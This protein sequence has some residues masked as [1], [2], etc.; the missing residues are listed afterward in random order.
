MIPDI[1]P[2]N[3]WAGNGSNTTFDFDFLINKESELQVLHTSKDG[4]QTELQLNKDYTIYQ[5]KK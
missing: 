5:I 3:T 2:V 1:T 4:I